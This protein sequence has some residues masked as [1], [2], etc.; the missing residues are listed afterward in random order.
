MVSKICKKTFNVINN[1]YS[2]RI[3]EIIK[4]APELDVK[5]RVIE[6]I[7]EKYFN[8]VGEQMPY[9]MITLLSDWYLSGELKSKN[10]DKVSNTEYPILS[11]HQ[12][13]RRNKKYP[14]IDGD[15]L[16][17]LNQTRGRKIKRTTKEKDKK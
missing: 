1:K 13:K 4:T 17:Y 10:V 7:T 9:Y 6:E 2:K 5:H 15:V 14:V 12:I 8:E 16:D 11:Q 3:E